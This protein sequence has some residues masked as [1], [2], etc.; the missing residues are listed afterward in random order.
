MQQ[1]I[2]EDGL[3]QRKTVQNPALG[4]LLSYHP[5]GTFSIWGNNTVEA[6]FFP[7]QQE[8][9]VIS[10]DFDIV[11]IEN[12]NSVEDAIEQ[13]DAAKPTNQAMSVQKL[14]TF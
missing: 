10:G 7:K 13:W 11:L 5:P 3:T 6:A 4:R 9:I 14:N 1:H 12:T 2:P 8:A